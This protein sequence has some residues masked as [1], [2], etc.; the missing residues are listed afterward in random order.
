MGGLVG[1]FKEG[2]TLQVRLNRGAMLLG[3]IDRYG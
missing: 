1:S 3:G 2:L